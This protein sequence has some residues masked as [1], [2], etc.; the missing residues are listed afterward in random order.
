MPLKSAIVTKQERNEVGIALSAT[1]AVIRASRPALH[2]RELTVAPRENDVRRHRADDALNVAVV[3]RKA[4]IRR[5]SIGDQRRARLHV[6]AHEGFERR[7][8]VVGDRGEAYSPRARVE[9]LRALAPG[10]RLVGVALADLARS[11][12]S[13]VSRLAGLDDRGVNPER[14]LRLIDLVPT[15]MATSATGRPGSKTFP[16]TS[17]SAR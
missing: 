8:R 15:S 5:I 7:C 13:A 3:A 16:L 6:D 1:Q 11:G 12:N 2:Q 14:N 4:E 9:V 10:L 17:A